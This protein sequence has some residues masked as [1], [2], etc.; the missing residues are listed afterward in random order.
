MKITG[1][2]YKADIYCPNCIVGEVLA[3]NPQIHSTVLDYIDT[4]HDL[5][6]L[7]KNWHPYCSVAAWYLWRA[8]DEGRKIKQPG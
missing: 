1:Y 7:A 3:D 8:A 4:E 5:E 2:V 6:K